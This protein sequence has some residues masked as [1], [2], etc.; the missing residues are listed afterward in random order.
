MLQ[1]GAEGDDKEMDLE[2]VKNQQ[3]NEKWMRYLVE[4]NLVVETQAQ[5]NEPSP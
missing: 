5:S 1:E 2:T 4:S 3:Q